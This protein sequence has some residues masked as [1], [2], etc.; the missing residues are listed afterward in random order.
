MCR[1]R[2][3]LIFAALTASLGAWEDEP[4]TTLGFGFASRLAVDGIERAEAGATA[5]V[6][7]S[8][9]G[10]RS[11][12]AIHRSFR[13]AEPRVSRLALRQSWTLGEE[14]SVGLSAKHSRQ[15]EVPAGMT[16]HSSQ[17][18]AV[19]T[20]TCLDGWTPSVAYHRDIRLQADL[21]EIRLARSFALTNLGAFLEWSAFAGWID[22][23][24]A[25]PDAAGAAVRDAF[26]YYGAEARLPYRIGERTMVV[27]TGRISGAIG[28]A[29]FWSPTARHGGT[30]AGVDLS[31][32]FDF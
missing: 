28:N 19:L 27:V 18:G 7:F 12:V 32:T 3:L 16:R 20:W 8:F 5:G 25:R 11:D 17:L 13:R 1:I 26:S 29:A 10:F 9:A 30:R 2:T 6:D 14:F 31:V 22:A 4:R 24:D 23:A 15:D 21:A